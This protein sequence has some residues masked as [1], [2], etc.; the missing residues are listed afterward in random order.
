M[1][2]RVAWNFLNTGKSS[3]G[4]GK[5]RSEFTKLNLLS[6]AKRKRMLRAF[7]RSTKALGFKN[8]TPEVLVC[9]VSVCTLPYGRVS[10]ARAS[11]ACHFTEQTRQDHH[12]KIGRAS[13][14]ER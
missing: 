6:A 4:I 3:S 8:E 1:N 9:R 2:T 11:C 13:C 14:R 7:L 10:V 12:L 5:I